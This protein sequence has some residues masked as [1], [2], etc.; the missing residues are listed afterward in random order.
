MLTLLTSENIPHLLLGEYEY[1]YWITTSVLEKYRLKWCLIDQE[2]AGL[3]SPSN[4]SF[5]CVIWIVILY[6]VLYKL[7]PFTEIFVEQPLYLKITHFPCR[8]LPQSPPQVLPS[9]A[10]GFT[11]KGLRCLFIWACTAHYSS[12]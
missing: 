8:H 2:K 4:F 5:L 9:T 12:Q 10:A 6:S 11:D 3:A 1:R 7:P